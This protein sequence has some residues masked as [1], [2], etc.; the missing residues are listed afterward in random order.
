LYVYP[1]Y[2]SNHYREQR[3]QIS[4]SQYVPSMQSSCCSS[5]VS[6]R[7]LQL[8]EKSSAKWISCKCLNFCVLEMPHFSCR[9]NILVIGSTT[10]VVIGLTWGGVRYPWSSAQVLSSLVIGLVGLCVFIIY[11]IYFCKPPI[12]S[13]FAGTKQAL[14]T[15]IFQGPHNDAYELDVRQWIRSEFHNS[16]GDG[17]PKLYVRASQCTSLTDSHVTHYQTGTRSSSKRARKNLP[18][19]RVSAFLGFHIAPA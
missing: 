13:P 17:G 3:V 7:H 10:S 8:S 9:G 5:C 19:G 16:R 12:V 18:S 11:E 2:T 15:D 1:D 14:L 6:R 4:T